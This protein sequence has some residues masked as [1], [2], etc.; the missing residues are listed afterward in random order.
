MTQV[1][2]LVT[3]YLKKGPAKEAAQS[4]TAPECRAGSP[5]SVQSCPWGQRDSMVSGGGRAVSI[6]RTLHPKHFL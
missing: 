2:L 5:P 1:T 3:L 4:R 6:G